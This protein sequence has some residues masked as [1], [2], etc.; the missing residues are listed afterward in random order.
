MPFARHRSATFRPA[1]PSLTIARI[2]SSANLLRLIRPPL[3]GGPHSMR[4]RSEGAGQRGSRRSA[5]LAGL[6]STP[7]AGHRPDPHPGQIDVSDAVVAGT[8]SPFDTFLRQLV[9]G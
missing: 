7:N 5:H 9:A 6:Y 1:S 3:N 4:G 2:C 8:L